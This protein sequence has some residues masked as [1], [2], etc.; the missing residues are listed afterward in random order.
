MFPS[1]PLQETEPPFG[2]VYVGT[3]PEGQLVGA[4]M[5]IAVGVRKPSVFGRSV[6]EGSSFET[7]LTVVAK[8]RIMTPRRRRLMPMPRTMCVLL[9]SFILTSWRVSDRVSCEEVV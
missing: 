3:C 6:F 4:G 7:A 1:L 2:S 9:L 8:R 5:R